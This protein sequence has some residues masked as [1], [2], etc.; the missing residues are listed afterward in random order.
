MNG[1]VNLVRAPCLVPL[2][3]IGGEHAAEEV[4]LGRQGRAVGADAVAADHQ[5]HVGLGRRRR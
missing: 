3:K 5:R 1:V 2:G 4:A